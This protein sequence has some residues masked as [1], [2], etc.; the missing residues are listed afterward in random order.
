MAAV[1]NNSFNIHQ[2]GVNKLKQNKVKILWVSM[3][4]PVSIA[5]AAGDQTFNY[6]FRRFLEDR[7]FEVRLVS[8]GKY[9]EKSVVE[10]EN[11]A[12]KHHIIY[13]NDPNV[14]LIY[15][16]RN[17]ES[18]FNP[19]NRHANLISNND[20]NEIISVLSQYRRENYSPDIV[21]LEWTNMVLLSKEIRNIFPSC[22][23]IAS[24]HDMAF[25]GYE[26]KSKY[27]RGL[28]GYIWKMKS[29]HLK[30]KEVSAL[31]NCDL[32]LPQNADNR[33]IL[34]REG[35]PDQKI[36]WLV[37]YFHDM[38]CCTRQSNQR[39]ILFFGA[40]GRPENYLSALW[41]IEKVI[42]LLQDLDIRFVVLGSNPPNKL[43]EMES[44]RIHITGFVTSFESYFE[45]AMCFV[46]P[47]VLG[48]GIKVK[49]IEG[50]S[51]GIPV[52]TNHIGIEGISAKNG[53]EYLHC[54]EPNE[55]A[56][57]VRK[58]K[59]NPHLAEILGESA[60]KFIKKNYSVEDSL[61]RYKHNLITLME[62]KRL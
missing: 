4:A 33:S 8:C 23:L 10:E 1:W 61:M 60:K 42:P 14:A 19:L 21:I 37:P 6:Y 39:D 40:M 49:V 29:R 58:I 35:I 7:R 26:R 16:L 20:V 43:K 27:Y 38:T 13:W 32:I 56:E 57:A 24:E 36:K 53:I 45:K 30:K 47:L 3:Y 62:D 44:K 51:S 12:V 25:V 15:R 17:I 52:L 46:A 9:K 54:E 31:F 34:L 11:R 18:K 2:K 55:Y 22:R 59:Y 5:A 50:L 41:F 48:A 28:K